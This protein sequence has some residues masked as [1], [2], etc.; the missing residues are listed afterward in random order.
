ML[1][2][3][4]SRRQTLAASRAL[5]DLLRRSTR[6]GLWQCRIVAGLLRA[7][8]ESPHLVLLH[9]RRDLELARLRFTPGFCRRLARRYGTEAFPVALQLATVGGRVA[10]EARELAA[11]GDIHGQFLLH[12]LAAELTEALAEHAQRRLAR[13]LRAG[14]TAR[15]SPGYPIWP[16]LADQTRVFALLRP[17]RIGV[18]LNESFQMVPEYS[19]SAIVVPRA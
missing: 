14:R 1:P 2:A 12:G 13:R 7:R 8:Q 15:Y 3:R 6:R 4:P 10:D 5:R 11:R 19:T 17:E 9:P 16:D 18:R